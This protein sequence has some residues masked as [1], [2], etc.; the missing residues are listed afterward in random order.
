MA[1]ESLSVTLRTL[2]P[3]WTGG[4][5][6]GK[7]DRLHESG[8][9]GSLRWWYEAIVRGLGGAACDPSGHT[10]LYDPQKPNNGLCDVCEL[11]GTT[12]W[13]RRF[14]L[15]VDDAGLSETWL[16]GMLN[17][18]PPDRNRGWFLHAGQM[19]TVVLKIVA[20]EETKAQMLALLHF[21]ARWGS[22]GARPQ[23]GYG[24]FEI[25]E[26]KNKPLSIHSWNIISQDQ[27]R[28]NYPDLHTFTFFAL[29]FEPQQGDWWRDVP[30]IGGLVRD[31]RHRDKV[32][33]MLRHHIIPTTPALKNV[34]RYGQPWSSGALPHQFFGT[35]RGEE[36]SRS[37]IA[38][39]WAYRLP[40][41]SNWQIRGWAY[42]PQVGASQQ[43]EIQQRLQA[44]LGRPET[45]LRALGVRYRSAEVS[46]APTA[47][48]FQP[49]TSA[50]VL[51][52]VG[53]VS[54]PEVQV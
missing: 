30:G 48:F 13:R 27:S 37:K 33:A 21:V 40:N 2:T 20:D 42:P 53:E 46:F 47:T 22:L 16:G 49:V 43:Q 18:K 12:G 10:C 38:L 5:E 23:L 11:F 35:L 50:Q 36:R 25:V 1:T 44:V 26:I 51:D 29:T 32:N 9:I 28:I 54:R 52:F 14:R 17:V 24:L 31:S 34:L 3:I 6:A 45:W 41:S 8:I 4:V 19:G 15:V 7:M 39:S